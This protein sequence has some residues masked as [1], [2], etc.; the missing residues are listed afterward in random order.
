MIEDMTICRFGA[1]KQ[2]EPTSA[3]KKGARDQKFWIPIGNAR[4]TRSRHVLL[5]MS[6]SSGTF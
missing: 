4:T 1:H 3:V 5:R 6:N 2:R